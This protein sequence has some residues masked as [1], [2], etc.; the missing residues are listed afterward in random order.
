MNGV[1]QDVRHAARAL[2]HSPAFAGIAVLTLALGIGANTAIFS[3][4]NAVLLRPLPYAASE[5]LVM[6]RERSPAIDVMSLSVPDFLAWRDQ[7]QVF[8]QMS[9][10]RGESFNLTGAGEPERLSGR[11]V[12]ANLLST[13]GIAPQLGRGF[14]LDD[15]APGAAAV[16]MPSHGFWQRR[17]GGDA[18][19]IGRTLT[20]GAQPLLSSA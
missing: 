13:L 2:W 17:F 16:A 12:S 15:D 8:A 3:V 20:L 7:N 1:Q 5:E 19:I 9:V 18:G 14:S 6:L 10:H 4:V 11:M